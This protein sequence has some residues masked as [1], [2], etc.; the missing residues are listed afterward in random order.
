VTC[1]TA[2]IVAASF[3]PNLWGPPL[4]GPN[5]LTAFAK[6]SAL[7]KP[8][9]T[10]AQS[11]PLERA[12]ADFDAGRYEEAVRALEP[13][14]NGNSPDPAASYWLGRA[15]LE[16]H[17]YHGAVD[18]LKRAVTLAPTN[19]EYRR[20]L[21]RAAAEIADR[22]HSFTMARR[23]RQEL[24]QAVRLDPSSLAIRRDLMGF[25]LEAPWLVGGGDG[26]ARTQIDAIAALDPVAGH[27]ARAA[28][29]RHKNDGGRARA[30]YE[31]VFKARPT[32]M[33]PY[34]EA[35]EFYERADDAAG[36][37]TAI[38]YAQKIDSDE[39][40]LLYFRGVLGILTNT[41]FD[42]TEKTLVTYLDRVP[43]R[44]D[45]PG[46]AA[47]HEWLGRLYELGGRPEQAMTEFR[48]ALALQSDRDSAR[49]RLRRLEQR[50][51]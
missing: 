48:K 42:K 33:A 1:C 23:V 6:A 47:T 37:R 50:K 43:P 15:R 28:Y 12:R 38:D 45:R 14:A 39:P 8:D 32:M 11:A 13:V 49:L 44:S 2:W 34:L 9:P 36:L 31:A 41:D 7:K 26:K 35:A 24:E 25:Y 51:K 21:A 17:D 3:I 30:E 22:E 29:W 27:L 46:P 4:G 5:R 19:A 18:A 20:W 40:Q 16:R 10:A